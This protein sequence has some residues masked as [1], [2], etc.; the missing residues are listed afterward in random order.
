YKNL[1]GKKEAFY[2]PKFLGKRVLCF[3]R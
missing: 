3:N 2:R 1:H